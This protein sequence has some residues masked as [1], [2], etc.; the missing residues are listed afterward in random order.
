[1]DVLV[2]WQQFKVIVYHQLIVVGMLQHLNVHIK[3]VINLQLTHVI[4]FLIT[5]N[6]LGIMVHV[7]HLQNVV[8]I[9]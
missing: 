3:L 4:C 2:K 9:V 7:K 1:M 8:I 5:L 6:V